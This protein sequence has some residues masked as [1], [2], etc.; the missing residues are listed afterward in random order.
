MNAAP[1]T[2]AAPTYT[3]EE[4]AAAMAYREH[5]RAVER[6]KYVR[7]KDHRLAYAKAYRTARKEAAAA[8]AAQNAKNPDNV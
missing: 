5:A 8:A 3:Q 6:A 4:I 1:A 2:P 7:N